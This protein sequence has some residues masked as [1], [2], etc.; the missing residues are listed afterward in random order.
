MYGLSY[1]AGGC[2]TAISED[3]RRD[4]K[5]VK[6]QVLVELD[7]V[8][9]KLALKTAEA[10][11][12]DLKAAVAERQ[13]AIDNARADDR[14]ATEDLTFVSKEFE[15]NQTMFRRGLI[16][17][18]T[19]EGV[20]SRMMDARFAAEQAKEAIN[21]ALSA[22]TRAEIALEIGVLE[23]QAVELDQADLT[24]TAPFDGAL[25]GFDPSIGTCVN[26][27]ALAAQLYDP[28]KKAVDVYVLISRLAA[29]EDTGLTIGAPV[30]VRRINAQTC[31]GE[32]AAID[33]EAD[34]ESQYV[35][36]TIDVEEACAPALY[37]NEAVEVMAIS[38][39]DGDTF[40]IPETA[41]LDEVIYLVK[42]DRLEPR[43][44][45]ILRREGRDVVI[46]LADAAGREIVTDAL[47]EGLEDLIDGDP[48]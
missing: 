37:L 26:E 9:T 12:M 6:G 23:M 29:T 44:V 36:V 46:R 14:R 25:I 47:A 11:L 19:M 35:Q 40:L 33:T 18:T 42:G 45:E 2:T 34:L 13:L 43:Q 5:A 16:N 22:K 32:I 21:T 8:H 48:A 1:Q 27:G 10:Q 15:R 31:G 17:E 38:G 28:K 41:L 24:L 20:E 3:A 7:D 30:R 39:M 4:Q